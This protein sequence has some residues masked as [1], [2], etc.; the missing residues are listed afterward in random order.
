LLLVYCFIAAVIPMWVLLQPRGYLGG[1]FLYGTM[2]A[3]LIGVFSGRFGLNYPALNMKGLTSLFNNASMVPLLFI[4]VACGACSGFHAI[5]SSGTTSKQLRIEPDARPI[6]YGGM[7][8]EGLVAL[9]ALSTLMILPDTKTTDPNKIYASGIAGYIN[10]LGLNYNIALNFAFLAFATFVYDTVDVC[11]R[12]GRYVFQE[13]VGWRTRAAHFGAAAITL[14]IPAFFLII[15]KENAY[16]VAWSLFG[17]SNQL[18]ASLTL[19]GISFWL[20]RTGKNP[21]VTF[22][23]MLFMLVMTFWALILQ[24]LPGIQKIV[25]GGS[26]GDIQGYVIFIGALVLLVLAL[27]MLFEAIRVGYKFATEARRAQSKS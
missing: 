27:W 14:L 16:K 21:L 2:L 5:V 11:T 19:L 13:L 25:S 20:W 12:L 26:L 22:L 15:S 24:I 18:L 17:T 23:P 6:G 1:C 9:L 7:L 3:A 4:T 10:L 8:L